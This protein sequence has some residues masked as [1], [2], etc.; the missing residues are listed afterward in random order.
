[1]SGN[2]NCKEFNISG[3]DSARINVSTHSMNMVLNSHVLKE[4]FGDS[5]G[6][7]VV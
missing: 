6:I 3:L 2:G 4:S 7:F 5:T 1:M